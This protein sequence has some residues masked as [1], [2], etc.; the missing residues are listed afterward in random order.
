MDGHFG[1]KNAGRMVVMTTTVTDVFSFAQYRRIAFDTGH[2]IMYN[3]VF[4]IL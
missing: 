2:F 4:N 1:F 3:E